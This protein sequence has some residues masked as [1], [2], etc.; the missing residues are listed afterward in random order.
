M[1]PFL[2]SKKL[3]KPY[4]NH[5]ICNFITKMCPISCF[6]KVMNFIECCSN[7]GKTYVLSVVKDE[8]VER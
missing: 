2:V 3:I 8:V 6:D 7:A 5:Y 4:G 1:T